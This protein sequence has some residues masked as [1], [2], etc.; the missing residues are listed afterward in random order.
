MCLELMT[1]TTM[2]PSHY[3]VCKEF[4]CSTR[5]VRHYLIHRYIHYISG[6]ED[7]R[8]ISDT[9]IAFD[10]LKQRINAKISLPHEKKKIHVHRFHKII[11]VSFFFLEAFERPKQELMTRQITTIGGAR[12]IYSNL[13]Y[14]YKFF[15]FDLATKTSREIKRAKQ[16]DIHNNQQM[17]QALG[18]TTRTKIRWV[19]KYSIQVR[20]IINKVISL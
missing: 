13:I 2:A 1:S 10:K 12:C 7:H 18:G 15:P 11:Q 6:I 5:D 3:Y 9:N 20:N 19:R 8:L 14:I 16:L 17:A 4:I